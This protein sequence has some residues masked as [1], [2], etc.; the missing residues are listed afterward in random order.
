MLKTIILHLIYDTLTNDHAH[1][2]ILSTFCMHII[3]TNVIFHGHSLFLPFFF[4]SQLN[5]N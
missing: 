3:Y 5:G 1:T 4:L 2:Q